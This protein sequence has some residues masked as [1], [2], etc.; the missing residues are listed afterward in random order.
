MSA[1]MHASFET[2]F[3]EALLDPD[4]PIPPCVTSHNA[5]NP[6]RRFAVYRNNVAAGLGN[7]LKNRFPVIEKIVGEEFFAAM[8]RAFVIKHPP[9]SPLLTSYGDELAAFIAAFEPAREVPYL[10]DVARLE[11]ARTRSYHAA[12]AVPVGA[13]RFAA[14][15]NDAVGDIRIELHPS[16]EIVRSRHPVVTIWAMNSGEQAL[17]PIAEWCSEDALIARPYLEVEVRALPPGGAAFLLALAAGSSL[18]EAAAVALAED[19]NFDL[20]GNIAGLIGSGLARDVVLP[21][22]H[23]C[24]QP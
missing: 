18:G 20:T 23:T 24:R 6:A 1:A 19:S 14:L 9:R 3:A 15:D 5:T 21:E 8:A 10:A 22:Q 2:S 12:D 13:E 17:A 4:R 11:A 7:A 16:V